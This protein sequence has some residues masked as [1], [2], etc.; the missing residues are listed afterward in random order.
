MHLGRALAHS[1]KTDRE[2]LVALINAERAAP[3]P[4]SVNPLVRDSLNAMM[5][6]ARRRAVPDELRVLA[7]RVGIEAPV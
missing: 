2:A 1:G 3:V 7:R 5:H 6:R 4:F